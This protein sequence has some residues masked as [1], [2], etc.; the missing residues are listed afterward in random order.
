MSTLFEIRDFCST[1]P[2]AAAPELERFSLTLMA[3]ESLVLL[4]EAGCG[5][6]AVLRLL[7][8]SLERGEEISGTIRFGE[9]DPIP[10]SRRPRN[11]L[12]VAYIPAAA[13]H[14]LSPQ[15]GTAQQLVRVIAHKTQLPARR[16]TRGTARCAR[17]SPR[18]TR[19][20]IAGQASGRIGHGDAV[21]GTACRGD[22]RDPR[23]CPLRPFLRRCLARCGANSHRRVACRPGE[24]GFRH[25][26]CRAHSAGR[27]AARRS[28]DRAAAWP[29]RR[30]G[31]GGA[32][33]GRPDPQ[34][35]KIA[36]SRF[37]ATRYRQAPP[38]IPARRAASAGAGPRPACREEDGARTRCNQLRAQ[39]GRLARAWWART[40]PDGADWRVRFS[41]STGGRAA[42]CSTRSISI[43]SPRR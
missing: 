6:D 30:G 31:R 41:A 5:K 3:G 34:L 33:D 11:P 25:C 22:C 4:G 19:D 27:G 20:G 39:T 17:K 10:A 26:V 38:R 37:A 16:R 40:A 18:R 15:A 35:H 24:A 42:S 43:C 36:V 9:G 2:G 23:A 13:Q 8:G 14:P 12:H 32:Y 1:K 29:R 7:G 21:L 28:H